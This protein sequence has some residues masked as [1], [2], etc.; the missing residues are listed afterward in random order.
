MQS[1]RHQRPPLILAATVIVA[2]VLSLLLPTQTYRGILT[3]KENGR[4]SQFLFTAQQIEKSKSG[5]SF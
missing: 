1:C 2:I 3:E 4:K 5:P